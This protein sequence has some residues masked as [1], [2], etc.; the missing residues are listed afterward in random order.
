MCN[1]LLDCYSKCIILDDINAT[2]WDLNTGQKIQTIAVYRRRI[3]S[4]SIPQ[5]HNKLVSVFDNGTTIIWDIIQGKVLYRFDDSS[6]YIEKVAISRDSNTCIVISEDYVPIVI[7]LLNRQEIH[8]LEGAGYIENVLLT[9]DGIKCIASS[10]NEVIVWDVSS[11][12]MLHKLKYHHR[13][14][15]QYRTELVLKMRCQIFRQIV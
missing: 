7:D 6:R 12:R 4:V 15:G 11:G 3:S 8:S 2:V 10:G 9:T 14:F 1:N 13:P 5:D